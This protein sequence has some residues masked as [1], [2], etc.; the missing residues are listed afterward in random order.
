T[1]ARTGWHESENGRVFVLPDRAIGKAD[2]VWLFEDGA[3]A[4]DYRERG[5][6]DEWRQEVAA[7]C[8][9]NS[10]LTFAVCLAFAAPLLDLVGGESGGIHYSGESGDGKTTAL[11]VAASVCGGPEYMKQWRAS[12][13]SMEYLALQHCDALLAMDELAQINAKVLG[14]TI[15]MLGNANGKN[16]ARAQGGLR[17]TAKFRIL[18]L[19]TGEVGMAAHVASVG[20]ATTA[21]MEG[22]MAEI[23]ARVCDNPPGIY[24]ALHGEASPKALSQRLAHAVKKCHG[25]AFPAFLA[26]LVKRDPDEMRETLLKARKLFAERYLTHE[27][28]NQV[29]RVADRCA[30]VGAAGELATRWGIT[31]WPAGA[32][33]TQAGVCFDAWL[34]H[35]GGEGNQEERGMLMQVRGFLEMHGEARFSDWRRSV[36]KD[37]HANR[38]MN[39]AGWRRLMDKD[40]GRLVDAAPD[41]G[42]YLSDDVV[43]EYLVLSQVFKNEVCK[44]F[45]PRTVAKLLAGRGFLKTEKEHFAVK[46]KPP[47]EAYQRMFH[48]LPA[49][50]DDE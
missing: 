18:F 38:V 15:Y 36:A 28:G 32:A 2:E 47:G 25:T 7:L 48:I 22:R 14:D 39:R 37:T 6:L 49:I 12:D 8:V 40:S 16:R 33:M 30:L 3:A 19:S 17:E 27:A 35:R 20:M 5:T 9:D 46:I 13:N 10:R 45:N 34:H 42:G 50:F 43:T 31:G 26:E 24:E 21:G 29:L 11:R 4:A 41:E 1:T 44:G 23:P